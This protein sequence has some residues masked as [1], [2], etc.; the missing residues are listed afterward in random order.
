MENLVYVAIFVATVLALEGLYILFL[1]NRSDQST[2][3]RRLQTLAG[4]F[5]VNRGE[6]ED[7]I[8]RRQRRETVIDRAVRLLP[9]GEELGLRL[10]RAGLTISPQRFVILCIAMGAGGWLAATIF[11]GN[12]VQAFPFVALAA[13][14][15]VQMVRLARK[16]MRAFEEQ[17]PGA[18][19]LLTRA[20]R[21][22]NSLSFGL[23]MVGDELP[24]PIGTEF[25]QV[26]QE[27][28]FGARVRDA[29]DNLAYRVDVP[30]IPFFVTAITIQ[31][32]TG[33]NLAEIL[34]NLGYVI[35]ERF[36][37]YGK[38]R[39]LT[40]IG[41]ASANLLAIW[42]LVMV[43]VMFLVSPR[44]IEPLWTTREGPIMVVASVIMVIVG[45]L[46]CRRMAIIKV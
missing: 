9:G 15:P 38:V 7:S 22:G 18:L 43:G 36:K 11:F 33:G 45:Y 34:D 37:L 30:D 26:A 21:A 31:S 25:A 35:R 16:R 5:K 29:L 20:L 19:E 39:A 17:F 44:Y 24:D 12:P 40:A 1:A 13:L 32:A 6:G 41:R 42:P 28:K 10:Y 4:E 23:Q 3:K 27:I 2:V 46:I 8:L 14:P